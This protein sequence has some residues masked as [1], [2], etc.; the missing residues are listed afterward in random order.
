MFLFIRRPARPCYY[1]IWVTFSISADNYSPICL[2]S[3]F[4]ELL[5]RVRLKQDWQNTRSTHQFEQVGFQKRS[6]M[7]YRVQKIIGFT[8][9]SRK[10]KRVPFGL[11]FNDSKK[12]PAS[13]EILGSMDTPYSLLSISRL[14][15]SYIINSQQRYHH[16]IAI[17]T[18]K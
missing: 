5:T 7:M 6:I 2:L 17:L 4:H 15:V 10:Y 12:V 3:V 11:T 9:V 14:F 8:E 1:S 18:L 16:S 13:A